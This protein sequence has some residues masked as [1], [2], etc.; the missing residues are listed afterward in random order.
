MT[1]DLHG[2]AATIRSATESE[3]FD[4]A[5]Q[6]PAAVTAN[7]TQAFT[8]AFPLDDMVRITFI[9]G[10]GK[11]GRQK[12]DDGCAKA[13]TSALRALGFEE[14]RAASCVRECAGSFK[15]QHDTGKNLKTVVVFP[16][17]VDASSGK[18]GDAKMSSSL[19]PP[20][21]L[22]YKIAVSTVPLFAN[23]LK[24]KFP[25]WSQKRAL[26]ILMDESLVEPL[27][28]LDASLMRGGQLTE[29]QQIFYDLE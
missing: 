8:S 17:I 16:K 2:L 1:E 27:D 20:N 22:E 14:D 4:L 7:I 3:T 10:A 5:G 29:D 28:D 15:L 24:A 26:L 12:Y 18:V 6:T 11:L 21:S 9:T 25:S 13:V 23:M 19:L